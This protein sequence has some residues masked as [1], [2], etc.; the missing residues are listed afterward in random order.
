MVVVVV[1]VVV[2]VVEEGGRE[3]TED[4]GLTTNIAALPTP[5]EPLY[6]LGTAATSASLAS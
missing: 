3:D 2:G 6:W 4:K 5:V 1:V